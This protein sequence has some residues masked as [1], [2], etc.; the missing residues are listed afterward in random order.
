MSW[1][2][3][4]VGRPLLC[5]NSA[6]HLCSLTKA[7]AWIACAVLKLSTPAGSSAQ[8]LPLRHSMSVLSQLWWY[9]VRILHLALSLSNTRGHFPGWRKN[10]LSHFTSLHLS[11]PLEIITTKPHHNF[12]IQ[13]FAEFGKPGSDVDVVASTKLGSAWIL[14]ELSSSDLNLN[15]LVKHF[16]ERGTPQSRDFLERQSDFI[17]HHL[18]FLFFFF[19]ILDNKNLV[20]PRPPFQLFHSL[21]WEL[22]WQMSCRRWQIIHGSHSPVCSSSWLRLS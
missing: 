15:S 16:W 20:L 9:V 10:I 17:P 14:V 6:Q 4:P 13:G 8:E 7:Q 11:L 21:S 22:S 12:K 18:P 2:C 3:R 19:F 5:E 1:E